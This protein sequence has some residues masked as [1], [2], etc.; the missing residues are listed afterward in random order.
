MSVSGPAALGVALGVAVQVLERYTL[1]VE[2]GK[3]S[4]F[5]PFRDGGELVIRPFGLRKNEP[6]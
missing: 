2:R 5:V 1:D 3:G 4:F 6:Y